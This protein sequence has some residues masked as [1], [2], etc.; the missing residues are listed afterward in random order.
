IDRVLYKGVKG[1]INIMKT[2]L[3][4]EPQIGRIDPNFGERMVAENERITIS[5]IGTE[6][7]TNHCM[8]LERKLNIWGECWPTDETLMDSF[9]SRR[10]VTVGHELCEESASSISSRL[11]PRSRGDGCEDPTNESQEVCNEMTENITEMVNQNSE[12]TT[13]TSSHAINCLIL[14]LSNKSD[15]IRR[16]IPTD[17]LEFIFGSILQKYI[18]H[19]LAVFVT[20]DAVVKHIHSL[21]SSIWPPV[22]SGDSFDVQNE[23]QTEPNVQNDT[24]LDQT[25]RILDSHVKY[26]LNS[27]NAYLSY[28]SDKLSIDRFLSNSLSKLTNRNS[29]KLFVYRFLELLLNEIQVK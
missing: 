19:L 8:Q 22:P 10:D 17:L 4:V 24:Y 15:P 13:T 27:M 11:G 25:V 9:D 16:L 21:H 18:N 23:V 7:E 3:P 28:I 26:T 6:V 5:S 20:K 2:A 1:A 14:L 12:L 29:N